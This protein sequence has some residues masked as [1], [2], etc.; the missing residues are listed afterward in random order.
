MQIG[1]YSTARQMLRALDDGN[2]SSVELVE[3]HIDRI[4]RVD[5]P[6][7]AIVVRDF[8]R[9]LE[10]AMVADETRASGGDGPLLGLPMTVKD[11]FFVDGLPATGGGVPER[12]DEI[13]DWDSPAVE[14]IKL[15]GAVILGKTNMPPYAADHQSV[16]PLYG[17]TSNPWDLNRTPGGSSGGAAAALAA[18]MTPLEI[19]GDYAGS[20]RAPAAY[21]G[22]FGH[23]S[24]E[25]VGPLVGHFPVGKL[26]NAAFAMAAQGPMARATRDLELLFDLLLTK[27]GDPGVTGWRLELPP[28]RTDRFSDMRVA[29]LPSFDWLPV[30]DEI[31]QALEDLSMNVSGAGAA[32]K[33][34][35]P[36]DGDIAGYVET[37]LRIFFAQASGD[38]RPDV[39]RE[40]AG[41]LRSSGDRLFAACADGW[42]ASAAD[43]LT[44]FHRREI[45]RERLRGFFRDWDVL[46]APCT[47]T[48]AFPHTDWAVDD[49]RCLDVNG[50]ATPTIYMFPFPGL[51][52]LSG[53]PGTAFPVGR[54]V[55]GLPVGLQAIGPYL[56]DRT[57]LRFAELVEAQ[58]GGFAPPEDYRT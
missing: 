19:G 29:I 35:D 54:T 37:Y 30:D 16:N 38:V 40:I 11:A 41:H 14:A 47:M 33:I 5:G 48:N 49:I 2:I 58:F 3:L 27:T 43:Y 18:G 46:L 20:I 26:P 39:A 52:N 34:V 53:H 4:E 24:S 1:P 22:V 31:S 12:A 56:G 32:V 23:K 15:A 44:W 36:F 45:Y 50:V 57:T 9:A 21:C 42:T 25:G 55:A 51:C 6:I 28:A 7:N 13:S 10:A 17:R 8:D